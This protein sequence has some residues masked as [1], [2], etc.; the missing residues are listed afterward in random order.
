MYTYITTFIFI[1]NQ[2]GHESFRTRDTPCGNYCQPSCKPSHTCMYKYVWLCVGVPLQRFNT[3]LGI[4]SQYEAETTPYCLSTI[5]VAQ[6]E[7]RVKIH[8]RV[9]NE[10][11]SGGA[12]AKGV[13]ESEVRVVACQCSGS[14]VS[15]RCS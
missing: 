9:V 12:L 13:P 7:K 10:H 8:L 14:C 11:Y 5:I 4:N 3:L 1:D 15:L 6:T 2:T